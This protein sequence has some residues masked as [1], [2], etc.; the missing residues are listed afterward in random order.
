MLTSQVRVIIEWILWSSLYLK[1]DRSYYKYYSKN[2]SPHSPPSP[3]S[4]EQKDWACEVSIVRYSVQSQKN[5]N[6]G[7][8]CAWKRE[9]KMWRPWI[10]FIKFRSLRWLKSL[11]PHNPTTS[12]STSSGK[13]FSFFNLTKMSVK[14]MFY[15]PKL[16]ILLI[17][18]QSHNH[19][20]PQ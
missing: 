5:Y 1:Y 15:L 20:R 14:Y 17:Q 7:E 18:F 6:M 19:R 12:T 13:C 2:P 10:L 16:K 8:N 3:H 4:Q 11:S 9:V